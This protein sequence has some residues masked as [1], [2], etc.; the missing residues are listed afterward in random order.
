MSLVLAFG[1]RAWE[2]TLRSIGNMGPLYVKTKPFNIE[3]MEKM[4]K[5]AGSLQSRH[6]KSLALTLIVGQSLVTLHT[7]NYRPTL[8]HRLAP[9][10]GESRWHTKAEV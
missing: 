3:K 2:M 1:T 10:G 5:M 4:E 8:R 7:T 6:L 9:V